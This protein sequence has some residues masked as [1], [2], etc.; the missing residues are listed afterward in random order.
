MCRTLVE[1][2]VGD[3]EAVRAGHHEVEDD[4]IGRITVCHLDTQ[5]PVTRPQRSISF[6]PQSIFQRVQG[7][8]IVI[9]HQDSVS[10]RLLYSGLFSRL[11]ERST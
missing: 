6:E 5:R 7:Q 9:Y 11:C 2:P 3:I 10:I 8:R 1:Q 4:Q